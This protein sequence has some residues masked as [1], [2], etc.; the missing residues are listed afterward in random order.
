[1]MEPKHCEPFRS[2]TR[3]ASS[4]IVLGILS[5][6]GNASAADYDTQR[7]D[8]IARAIAADKNKLLDK[9]L[10]EVTKLLSLGTIPQ[11]DDTVNIIDLFLVTDLEM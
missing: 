9:S 3:L 8:E 1:M 7:F 6:T 11:P 10:E 2:S 5:C 4:I